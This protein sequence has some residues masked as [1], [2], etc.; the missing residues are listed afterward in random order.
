[1]SPRQPARLLQIH[2]SES[3]RYDGKPLHEAIAAKC[4]ESKAAGITVLRG[5]EGYGETAELYRPHLLR[6]GQP[7]EIVIVDT[8][9]A[10]AAL[11]PELA[12]MANRA[13]LA[14]SDVAIVRVESGGPA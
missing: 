5:L 1:M 12:A 9:E 10:I 4:R 6:H 13:I 2:A 7:V 11:L 3:D 8:P 14:V